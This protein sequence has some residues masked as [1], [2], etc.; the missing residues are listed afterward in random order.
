MGDTATTFR[1]LG[2]LQATRNERPLTIKGVRRRVLLATLLLH[3]NKIVSIDTLIEAVW[4]DQPPASAVANIRTYVHDLRLSLRSAGDRT[5]RLRSYRSGY[6]LLVRPEELDMLLFNDLLRS[7][8]AAM[9]RRDLA[10]AVTELGQAMALWRDAPLKDLPLSSALAAKAAVLEEYRWSARSLCVDAQLMLGQHRQVVGYL[11]EMVADK[12][13][14]EHTWAQLVTALSRAGRT[15]EALDCFHHAR[16]EFI[17]MLG[18]EP[19]EELRC[20]HE[21]ALNTGKRSA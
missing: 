21:A 13:L 15:G 18:I 5:A 4:D 14:S 20:A 19:G 6:Q 12:P 10:D 1:V 17:D 7:G 9:A 11:R 8:E 16:A 2:P 3:P